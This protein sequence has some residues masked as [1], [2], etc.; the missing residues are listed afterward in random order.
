MHRLTWVLVQPA[1]SGKMRG[2]W[3]STTGMGARGAW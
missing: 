2:Y 3:S 1:Q